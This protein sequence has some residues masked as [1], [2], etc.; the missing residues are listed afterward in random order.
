M[1]PDAH[2]FCVSHREV[3]SPLEARREARRWDALTMRQA[4]FSFRQI[5]QRLEI[6]HVAAMN[7]VN[8]ALADL[9]PD[10]EMVAELRELRRGQLDR[11]L[12]AVWV[13]ATSVPPD[14][15]A[16][17]R[18]HKLIGTLMKL[19][20]LTTHRVEHSGPGGAPIP[21]QNVG[22]EGEREVLAMIRDELEKRK[23]IEASV[24]EVTAGDA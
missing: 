10:P 12:T 1:V 4:G 21:V 22:A 15:A 17:D 7:L 5:G 6:S 14:L 20:G 23:A 16:W 3:P 9:A 19:D 8:R 2:E 11:L 18:A 24:V 13:Q